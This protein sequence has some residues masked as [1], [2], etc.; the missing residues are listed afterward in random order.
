[1]IKSSGNEEK[2]H[3]HFTPGEIKVKKGFLTGNDIGFL[4]HF[5]QQ[6]CNRMCMCCEII[7]FS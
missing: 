6:Q 4:P 7:F 1:M 3:A 5:L 2:I